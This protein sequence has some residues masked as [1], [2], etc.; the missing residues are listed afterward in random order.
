M[1][2]YNFSI[3]YRSVKKNA[4]ALSRLQESETIT[5]VFP[6]V[7]KPICQA[8]IAKWDN[9]SMFE[10]IVTKSENIEMNIEEDIPKEVLFS[11]ALTSLDRHKAQQA[12]RDI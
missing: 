8:V 5:T 10:R 1:S 4:D 9:T 11:T 3:K 6:D 2:N 12:D 7:I